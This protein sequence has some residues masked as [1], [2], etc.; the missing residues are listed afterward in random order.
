MEKFDL[1]KDQRNTSEPGVMFIVLYHNRVDIQFNSFLPFQV[2][3]IL[4]FSRY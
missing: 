3:N 2:D 4:L 1:G